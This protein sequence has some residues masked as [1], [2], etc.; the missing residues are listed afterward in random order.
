MPLVGTLLLQRGWEEKFTL[1]FPCR[2]ES[3]LFPS[4]TYLFLLTGENTQFYVSFPCDFPYA[5]AHSHTHMAHI[6]SLTPN[7]RSFQNLIRKGRMGCRKGR[8]LSHR[9][10]LKEATW[11]NQILSERAFQIARQ[12]LNPCGTGCKR[13]LDHSD[14][15]VERVGVV[16]LR[17]A[18]D[19]VQ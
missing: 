3:I 15:P 10:P 1:R 11:D 4:P 18:A 17:T 19:F 2:R 16:E 9:K 13:Y 7:Y 12:G 5:C 6:H 14:R 8:I